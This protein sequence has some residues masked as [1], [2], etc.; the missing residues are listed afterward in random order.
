[1]S[2]LR[3]PIE[4]LLTPEF[5]GGLSLGILVT[6]VSLASGLVLGRR[7]VGWFR[8]TGLLISIVSLVALSLISDVRPTLW[9]GT[10]L[11]ALAGATLHRLPVRWLAPLLFAPGAVLVNMAATAS[12]QPWVRWFVALVI[13]SAA[14]LVVSFVVTSPIRGCAPVLF[15]IFVLG[16]FLT[17]PDTEEALVLLGIAVPPAFSALLRKP[18]LIGPAGAG[19]LV[20]VSLWVISQGAVGRPASVIPATACLGLLLVEP[21]IAGLSARFRGQ[22]STRSSSDFSP[23]APIVVQLVLVVA[24][25]RLGG[26]FGS[27]APATAVSVSLLLSCALMTLWVA[28]RTREPG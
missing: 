19:S 7:F 17:V 16:V 1:M 18:A 25:A 6:V 3:G 13:V 9:L 14:P 15:S 4:A 28:R 12:S 5:F 23:L 26:R 24:I 27:P 20:G 21:S 2:T 10:L 11:L 8:I 22:S